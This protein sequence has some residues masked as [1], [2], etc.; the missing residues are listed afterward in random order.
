MF[1]SL[2]VTFLTSNGVVY[3]KIKGGHLRN[4]A[5]KIKYDLLQDN[6]QQIIFRRIEWWEYLKLRS[7]EKRL[8]VKSTNKGE[9]CT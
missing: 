2:T 1:F 9:T 4:I 8:L 3:T 5:Q 6:E 7:H